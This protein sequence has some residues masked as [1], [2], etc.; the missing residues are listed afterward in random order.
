MRRGSGTTLWSIILDGGGGKREMKEKDRIFSQKS[1]GEESFTFIR[2][3][4]PD[5]GFWE[6][7]SMAAS[8]SFVFT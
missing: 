4:K 3:L 1:K 8:S 6:I 7:I 5:T 2:R